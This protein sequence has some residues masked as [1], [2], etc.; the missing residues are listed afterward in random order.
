ME[1]LPQ[2]EM[3][4]SLPCFKLSP[5]A[6]DAQ[7]KPPAGFIIVPLLYC[8]SPRRPPRVHVYLPAVN[9][10]ALPAIIPSSQR[11]T[12][13]RGMSI[14]PCPHIF[15]SYAWFYK[16]LLENY[17]LRNLLYFSPLTKQ[18][19]LHVSYIQAVHSYHKYLFIGTTDK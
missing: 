14:P 12:N 17:V 19:L 9:V 7:T 18:F 2:A 11:I 5:L 1:K 15:T 3:W 4:R 6:A 13:P 10:Y 16:V 8:T